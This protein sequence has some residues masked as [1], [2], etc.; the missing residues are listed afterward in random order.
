MPKI[1]THKGVKKRFRLTRTGKVVSACAYTGHIK[2]TK[3]AKRKRRLRRGGVLSPVEAKRIRR[4]L[5]VR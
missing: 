2:A 3:S 4:L 5:A 1:K